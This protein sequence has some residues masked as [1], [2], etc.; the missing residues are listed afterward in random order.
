MQNQKRTNWSCL[1]FLCV[2]N[3]ET[4]SYASKVI[5]LYTCIFLLSSQLRPF[6]YHTTLSVL[7]L[8]QFDNDSLQNVH[9][10]I[11]R[12]STTFSDVQHSAMIVLRI[13]PFAVMKNGLQSSHFIKRWLLLLFNKCKKWVWYIAC[14]QEVKMWKF[15]FLGLYRYPKDEEKD[16]QKVAAEL[17]QHLFVHQSLLCTTV[18]QLWTLWNPWHLW[19]TFVFMTQ[20]TLQFYSVI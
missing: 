3:L 7:N 13:G 5:F 20:G 9:W 8:I 2:T 19:I 17:H 11:I 18:I 10:S 12:L 1:L 6:I 14:I 16:D 15:M 4:S